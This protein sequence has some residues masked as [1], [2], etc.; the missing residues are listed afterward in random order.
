MAAGDNASPVDVAAVPDASSMVP[1]SNELS[2]EEL[3]L[4]AQGCLQAL[5]DATP[6]M[7]AATM[8]SPRAKDHSFVNFLVTATL[9]LAMAPRSQV[10]KELRI[11]Q[12]FVKESDGRYWVKMPAELNKNAKPTL[13]ALPI[14]LTASFDLYIAC[15]RPRLLQQQDGAA[16]PATVAHSYLFFKRNG[17]APRTDFS[18]LTAVATQQLLGRPVNAHAF[19][20][21]LITTYYT[22]G[23]TQSDMNTLASIMAHDPSTARNYYYR[24]QMA[25]AALGTSQRMVDLLEV[26]GAG[27]GLASD[28][29]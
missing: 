27:E 29:D 16:S 7:E 14:E 19:R 21:A 9:C 8:E 22:A 6:E 11:G 15:I 2:P 26:S 3:K 25:Q 20:S 4:V 17:S 5:K 10:L 24:P 1:D 18:E 28:L 13:F 23:A 12:T